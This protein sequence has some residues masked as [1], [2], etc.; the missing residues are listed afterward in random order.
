M[1]LDY[2]RS[3]IERM[4]AQVGR[5]GWEIFQ[6]QRGRDSNGLGQSP[7]CSECSIKSSSDGSDNQRQ[8]PQFL[9]LA[10]AE[11]QKESDISRK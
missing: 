11:D 4:R 10:A 9:D 2:V 7:S 8:Q 5:Q 1:Q 3:E 6:L